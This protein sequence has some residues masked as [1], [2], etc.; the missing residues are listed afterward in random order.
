MATDNEANLVN[1]DCRGPHHPQQYWS[2]LLYLASCLHPKKLL[3][4][5]EEKWVQIAVL[6]HGLKRSGLEESTA[7]QKSFQLPLGE[8]VRSNMLWRLYFSKVLTLLVL[9]IPWELW[10]PQEPLPT[11]LAQQRQKSLQRKRTWTLVSLPVEAEGP[12]FPL[13]ALSY[14]RPIV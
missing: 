2:T 7:L 10:S 8:K 6:L 11:A 4:S 5:R 9:R 14:L 3:K 1:G 13:S 12:H